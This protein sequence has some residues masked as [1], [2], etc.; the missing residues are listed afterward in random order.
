MYI[1]YKHKRK[2]KL[3]SFGQNTLF[4]KKTTFRLITFKN[5]FTELYNNDLFN[6][7][8]RKNEI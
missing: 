6:F 2:L 5:T 1:N 8:G 4:I 7:F 3:K